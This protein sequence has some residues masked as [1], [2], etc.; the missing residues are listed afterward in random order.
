MSED[1]LRC[2]D[3]AWRALHSPGAAEAHAEAAGAALVA[4]ARAL[5]REH[6]AGAA[7]RCLELALLV[8]PPLSAA[9]RAARERAADEDATAAAAPTRAKVSPARAAPPPAAA[10]SLPP[11]APALPTLP[12]FAAHAASRAP[13]PLLLRGLARAW[14]AV[15]AWGGGDGSFL[16]RAVGAAWAPAEVAGAADGGAGYAGARAALVLLPL[17]SLLAHAL[18]GSRAA[19]SALCG[20]EGDSGDGDGDGGDDDGGD[21]GG[22]WA[23]ASAGAGERPSRAAPVVLAGASTRLFPPALPARACSL[24]AA[25][26]LA[27][28]DGGASSSPAADA[29]GREPPARGAPPPYLAH[30]PLSALPAALRAM[31]PAPDY[32][33]LP[34]SPRSASVGGGDVEANMWAGAAGCFSPLHR[35]ERDNVFVQVVG[36]KR[37]RLYRDDATTATAEGGGGRCF[38]ARE[39]PHGNTSRVDVDAPGQRFPRFPPEPD[40]DVVLEPGDAVYVPAGC[41]HAMRAETASVSVSHWW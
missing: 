20:C 14:P 12:A 17:R 28:G 8:A 34:P 16:A 11:P 3:A 35:D 24:R 5:S 39:P 4:V 7:R 22:D 19:A 27:A 37:V 41:W 29:G 30:H 38:Y 26:A 32:T 21:D 1:L 15:A 31:A 25:T 2:A 23:A 33:A 10:E 18:M 36:R 9:A 6:G 40:V 13:A